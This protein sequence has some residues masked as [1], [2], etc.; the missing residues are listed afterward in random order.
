[1]EEKGAKMLREM[2]TIFDDYA[3]IYEPGIKSLVCFS[4]KRVFYILSRVTLTIS[5]VTHRFNRTN[6]YPL[7]TTEEEMSLALRK[8]ATA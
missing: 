5:Q 7:S 3:F 4:L 1:M 2:E 8:R 6:N